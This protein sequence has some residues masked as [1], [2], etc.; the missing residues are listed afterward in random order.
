MELILKKFRFAI[1][2]FAATGLLAACA[3]PGPVGLDP[4]IA[5]AELDSL[6][7]PEAQDYTAGQQNDLARPLDVLLVSVFGVEELT[8]PVRVGSGGFFDF[9]LIGAVQ[10]NGRSL[11]E[12]SYELETRLAGDYVLNPDV[13]IEFEERIGQTFTVGGEVSDP[14]QYPI[15][16]RM[17]LMEAVASAG[18]STEFSQLDDVLIFREIGGERYVGVY[19]MGAIQ[20]G[21]YPDP[22]IYA[23][24]IVMVGD[25][26]NRRLLAEV[27]RYTQLATN[28]LILL[29]RAAR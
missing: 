9:P 21:N 2:A 7:A 29:E 4:A 17:T 1:L 11:G 13:T 5:I 12:I 28:P 24:D 14:G 16:R 15:L 8:R 18:G 27:L 22:V 10:A 19:D 3:K 25:S 23:H 6:P 20:R 26:P